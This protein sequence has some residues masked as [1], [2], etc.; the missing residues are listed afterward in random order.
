MG[1]YDL[2]RFERAQRGVY[3]TALLE[4]RAGRKRTHWMWFVFPQVIGLGLS[5]TSVFYAIG[6]LDE[7]KAYLAHPVLGTR[8]REITGVMNAGA[9]SNPA[10]ILGTIDAAKFWSSM[11]LFDIVTTDQD[12]FRY[13]LDKFFEGQADEETVRRVEFWRQVSSATIK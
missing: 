4:I 12:C 8:L 11:T 9:Q 10:G 2:G 7:A 1:S 6:S 13:A 3:E 5:E